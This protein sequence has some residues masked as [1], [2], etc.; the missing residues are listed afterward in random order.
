MIAYKNCIMKLYIWEIIFYSSFH[1]IFISV[2][3]LKIV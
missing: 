2:A 1:L 3:I